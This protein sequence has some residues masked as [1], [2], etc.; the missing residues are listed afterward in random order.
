MARVLR[1]PPM[2][3]TRQRA[4]LFSTSPSVVVTTAVMLPKELSLK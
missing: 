3:L 2:T 1:K 4:A